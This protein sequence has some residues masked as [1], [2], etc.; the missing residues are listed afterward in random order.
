MLSLHYG[1]ADG[2]NGTV[3]LSSVGREAVVCAYKGIEI[4]SV[5]EVP[6]LRPSAVVSGV[7]AEL[8]SSCYAFREDETQI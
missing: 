8:T 6:V 5:P 1:V 4:A 2:G 3:V 7:L